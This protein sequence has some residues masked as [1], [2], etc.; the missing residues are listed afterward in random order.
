MSMGTN[1]NMAGKGSA[2]G[3][4]RLRLTVPANAE[5]V[6]LVRHA[7]SGLAE[8]IGMDRPG[9]ADLKTV[10]TEACMNAV[11]HAYPG[12]PGPIEIDA[13]PVPD[14]LRIRIADHGVGFQPRP[15][16]DSPGSSLR[17]GLSLVA[18]LCS[19]FTISGRAG[20]GTEVM[21]VSPL[22]HVGPVPH[23]REEAEL[24]GAPGGIMITADGSG[25]LPGVLSRAVSAFAVRREL[26]VDQISDAML[27]AESVSDFAP[28]AFAGAPPSFS[29]ADG[30][31]GI[32]MTV[33]PLAA[34]GASRLRAGLELPETGG[35]V[36]KLADSVTV[37]ER[38]DGEYVAFSIG[39]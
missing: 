21:M 33:G 16:V 4:P 6:A 17:L 36:E 22:R 34:G 12:E 24:D 9:I 19:S 7:L 29:L 32:E 31:G 10:V 11:V 37:E 2:E 15:D 38:D 27:L 1:P 3:I 23:V 5:N 18:A 26:S 35:S 20:E 39:Q 30:E 28:E 13:E 14:G 25:M 8:G